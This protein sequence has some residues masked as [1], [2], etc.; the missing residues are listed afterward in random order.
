[1]L[2]ARVRF[3]E[4]GADKIAAFLHYQLPSGKAEKIFPDQTIAAIANVSGG[5]PVVIN[6]FALRMLDCTA[7]SSG[8]AL[9][10]ANLDS[11][12][13]ISLD[14]PAEESDITTFA[15]RLQQSRLPEPDPHLLAR[16]WADNSVRLKL[17]TGVTFCFACAA[18][19]ATV[20]FIH[21]DVPHIA[22]SRTA[23][24]IGPLSDCAK[25]DLAVRLG[26]QGMI[27]RDDRQ[28]QVSRAEPRA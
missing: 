10:Q 11:A 20:A 7:V 6:R 2:V 28:H 17:G 3:H 8:N 15:D 16:I 12:T 25:P 13:M 23:P 27:F 4:L 19:L 5:D 21:P 1:M 14:M 9:D 26:W 18:V 24:A 22:A